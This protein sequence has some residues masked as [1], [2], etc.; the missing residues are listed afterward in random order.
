MEL[1]VLCGIFFTF[2]LNDGTF[3]I[4]VSIPQTIDMNMNDV[5]S[6]QAKSLYLI[7]FEQPIELV[8]K[9]LF[10]MNTFD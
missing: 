7:K 9:R 10:V 8:C 5:M 1:I 4:I 2:S 6:Y 3:H